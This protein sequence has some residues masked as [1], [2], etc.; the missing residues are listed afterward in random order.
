M[1]NN[2]GE[3]IEL[4]RAARSELHHHET[5][6]IQV[7]VGM[8]IVL[9]FFVSAIALLFGQRKLDP[10][11]ILWTKGG[12]L[13]L[14]M[15]VCA[16]FFF[17]IHRSDGRIQACRSVTEQI[18]SRL[19]EGTSEFNRLLVGGVVDKSRSDTCWLARNKFW[20]YVGTIVLA[21]AALG[22]FLFW[23]IQV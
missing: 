23:V 4:Y 10:D 13:L 15:L 7:C 6:Y 22:C 21:L 5:V 18:E 20:I 2:R 11:Y 9:T 1:N 12:V 16:I 19:S 3:L 8:A 17:Q 14:A